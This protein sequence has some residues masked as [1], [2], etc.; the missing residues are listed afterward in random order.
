MT[1]CATAAPTA[2]PTAL[3]AH[4][5]LDGVLEHPLA[6]GERRLQVGQDEGEDVL[7]PPAR[8]Q[9]AQRPPDHAPGARAAQDARRQAPQQPAGAAVV[10]AGQDGGQQRRQPFGRRADRH[11]IGK[12]AAQDT[13]QVQ[14]AEET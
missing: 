4:P 3:L 14:P 7:V 9:L 1:R 5:L 10:D 2:Q 11:R 8:H 6:A 13:G 12:E